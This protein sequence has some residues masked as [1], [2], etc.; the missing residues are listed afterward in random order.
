[1]YSILFINLFI[2]YRL[3][4]L[5]SVRKNCGQFPKKNKYLIGAGLSV[6]LSVLLFLLIGDYLVIPGFIS[7]L[8]F[9]VIEKRTMKK[10]RKEK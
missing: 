8:V 1:M 7:V 6:I 10:S 9:I 4:Y 2:F 3:Y 5:Y